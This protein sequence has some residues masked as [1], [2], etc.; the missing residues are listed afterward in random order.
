MRVV[1]IVE[2][3]LIATILVL[4]ALPLALPGFYLLTVTLAAL[5]AREPA[6]APADDAV[7]RAE[8]A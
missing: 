8:A 1:P 2:C 6:T 3:Y 4:A 5:G 7:H